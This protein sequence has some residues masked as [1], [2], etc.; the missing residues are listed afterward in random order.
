MLKQ[1]K[2]RVEANEFGQALIAWQITRSPSEAKR[3][4]KHRHLQS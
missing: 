2:V 1:Q 3:W 4:L